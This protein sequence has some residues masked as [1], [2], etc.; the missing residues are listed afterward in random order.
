MT[1]PDADRFRA[2]ARSSPWRWRTL[3]FTH[4]G[5]LRGRV[6]GPVRA[7]VRRPSDLR[8]EDLEG[9]VLLVLRDPPRRS[10]VMTPRRWGRSGGETVV[11]AP[12]ATVTPDYD[13][14]GLVARRP[15]GWGLSFDDPMYQD[16]RWVAMLDPV[17]LADGRQAGPEPDDLPPQGATVTDLAVV[18]HHGREA[19]EALVRPTAAYEPRCSCCPLLLSEQIVALER[20]AA[21]AAE[22]Y[23]ASLD[24]LA[25]RGFAD[26]HRVRLDAG[27]GVCVLTEEIGGPFPGDGH[28]LVIE[29]VDE[30]MGDELFPRG[31]QPPS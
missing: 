30:P 21:G 2:L 3:R 16:Y 31:W 19:W 8:V 9:A 22:D 29:A 23:R 28:E 7:W 1:F 25:A 20:E 17:E 13:D 24:A 26:A 27:T 11:L 15:P 14:W 4:R 10:G 12:A 5:S 18:H 6:E